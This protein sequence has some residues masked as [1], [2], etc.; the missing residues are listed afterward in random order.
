MVV[1]NFNGKYD[2]GLGAVQSKGVAPNAFLIKYDAKGKPLWQKTYGN[3]DGTSSGVLPFTVRVDSADNVVFAGYFD[4]GMDFG[5][6]TYAPGN[7]QSAGFVAKVKPNGDPVFA[8]QIGQVG[9]SAVQS[10]AV[11]P[12]ADVLVTGNVY[13]KVDF[14]GGSVGNANAVSRYLLRLTPAGKFVFA[15]LFSVDGFVA[16]DSSGNAWLSASAQVGKSADL[17]GGPFTTGLGIAKYDPGGNFVA[18][19]A[20][21]YTCDMIQGTNNPVSAGYVAIDGTDH[22]IISAL[23]FSAG[24]N[25]KIDFGGG[26]TVPI[27]GGNILLASLD[28]S[29][30]AVFAKAFQGGS[31][32]F[33]ETDVAASGNSIAV[34]GQFDSSIDFGAGKLVAIGGSPSIL[35][36]KLTAAG[37]VVWGN[38][39]TGNNAAPYNYQATGAAFAAGG[40]VVLTGSYKGS[41]L[42]FGQGPLP[43]PAGMFLA[44]LPP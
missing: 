10:L 22:F 28:K 2:F 33:Y 23:A 31:S 25:C 3:G 39:Y 13:G 36:A 9:N 27:A 18:A 29:G 15:K 19:K 21:P 6:S 40:A 41:S 26:K 32:A 1:G 16:A 30:T 43:G 17:G 8:A 44:K 38:A 4:G 35:I 5:G 14:G 7:G 20:F 37:S 12:N 34:C 42:D 24:L 11:A